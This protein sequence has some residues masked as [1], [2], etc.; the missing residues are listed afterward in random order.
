MGNMGLKPYAISSHHLGFLIELGYTV[1]A[2]IPT[3]WLVYKLL[4]I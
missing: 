2:L 4:K 3:L 1:V